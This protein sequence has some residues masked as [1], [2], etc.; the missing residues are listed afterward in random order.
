MNHRFISL[1]AFLAGIGVML[2]AFG[3]HGLRDKVTDRMLDTWQTGVHYHVLHAL[4]LIVVGILG[5]HS[6]SRALPKVGGLFIAGIVVFSGTLYAYVATGIK[7]FAMIT[8]LGGVCFILGW[9]VLTV[10]MKKGNQS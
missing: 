8:P 10:A 1:G 3:T 9:M 6:A 4:A 7:V 2:G 5:A